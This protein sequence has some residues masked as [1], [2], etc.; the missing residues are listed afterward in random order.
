MMSAAAL[1]SL[2]A[3][4]APDTTGVWL[5]PKVAAARQASP[6]LC[7]LLWMV[8]M[9]MAVSGVSAASL[10]DDEPDA[11]DPASTASQMMTPETERAVARGLAWLARQQHDDGSFG[12]GAYRGNVA[13]TALAG[14]ALMS[15]GNTPERGPRGAAV[16]R[17][18]DYL[19]EKTQPSGY[20]I[21]QPS[22]GHGPMY[23]HGFAAM[24]LAECYGMT[25]REDLRPKLVAAVQL[26]VK[27]QNRAGG[28]RYQPRPADADVSVTVCQMMALRAARNAGL[29]VSEET[30]RRSEEY[31][32]RCQNADGGF[33]YMLE[34]P[35]DSAFARSAAAV[36]GLNSVGMYEGPRID[37][38]I[39]YLLQFTPTDRPAREE[40]YYL[41]G[42][43]YAVQAMWQRGGE[44][45]RAWFPAVR[46]QFVRRQEEDGSWNSRVVDRTYG[47]AMALIV[48]Q[49]PNNYLP[50]FQR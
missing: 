28:W 2:A 22:A 34:N 3:N 25:R 29:H 21:D 13:V 47:T 6:R 32:T 14:M 38:A 8:F 18:A 27:S 43:Y 37:Q 10:A 4:P 12:T 24:F 33:M 9:W 50:I 7:R 35:G 23:G 36:V 31:V 20:I 11:E 30:I 26:I 45:W 46:D 15:A 39:D 19:L 41:Y 1:F 16:A 17:I 44:P 5:V 42:Q 48:L 40:Q 49:I